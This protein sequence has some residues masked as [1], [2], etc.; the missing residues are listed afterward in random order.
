M[1]LRGDIEALSGRIGAE[2]KT[3][4]TEMVT[5]PRTVS[6]ASL[7]ALVPATGRPLDVVTATLTGNPT[8][9]PAAGADRQVLRLALLAGPNSRTV[10][11]GSSVRLA[12]GI[13]DRSLSVPANQAGVLGLEFLAGLGTGGTWVLFSKYATAG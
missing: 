7:A 9:T 10:T 4:R 3:V 13:S 1:S 11:L 5:G 12:T 6:Y 2:F 8:I